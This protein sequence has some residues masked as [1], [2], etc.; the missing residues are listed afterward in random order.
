MARSH[1]AFHARGLDKK[2]PL[3]LPSIVTTACYLQG[4]ILLLLTA[5]Y[6]HYV[7]T[8]YRPE[9][10]WWAANFDSRFLWINRT[11]IIATCAGVANLLLRAVLSSGWLTANPY[12]S[13]F[14]TFFLALALVAAPVV[15]WSL[16][17][18]RLG[19]PENRPRKDYH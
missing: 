15:W 4:S 19:P 5:M 8:Y 11:A 10:W 7:T 14:W 9:K 3:P 2:R 1:K 18:E 12:S 17:I 6:G 16:E 13:N